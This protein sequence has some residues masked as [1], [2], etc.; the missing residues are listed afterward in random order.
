M[1]DLIEVDAASRTKVEETRQLLDNVQYAPTRSRFKIYLIDE[2]HMFSKHSFNALLKTLEEP[3]SHV[4]FLLATTDP[5][6]LP[7]TVLSRCL[8]FGLKKVGPEIIVSQLEKIL[9]DEKIPYDRDSLGYLARASDGSVRDALSL[10]DQAI[11]HGEGQLV[12]AEIGKMLGLAQQET[13]FEMLNLVSAGE[14]EQLLELTRQLAAQG[15]N[16]ELIMNQMLQVLRRVAVLQIVGQTVDGYEEHGL[17]TNE[18]A[19]VMSPENC[20][21]FYEIFQRY[22][23]QFHH[24]LPY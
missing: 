3:P 7:V 9:T 14:G 8:K 1:I 10:L 24:F 4:K 17:E 12:S 15:L 22:F 6:K 16:Y 21:L 18:L 19:Q 13:I 11:V 5:E 23:S 20:Q 2:V